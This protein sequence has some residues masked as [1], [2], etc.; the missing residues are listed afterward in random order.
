MFQIILSILSLFLVSFPAFAGSEPSESWKSKRAAERTDFQMNQNRKSDYQPDSAEFQPEKRDWL[1]L[2]GAFK[3]CKIESS[4]L[5]RLLPDFSG[6]DSCE[7]V[8]R[9]AEKAGWSKHD[10]F[11]A[12]AAAADH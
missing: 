3:V 12:I 11:K 9:D 4:L 2:I 5:D 8:M 10:I 7:D 6:A 1:A